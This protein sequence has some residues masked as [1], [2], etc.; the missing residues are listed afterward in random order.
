MTIIYRF[1]SEL[2]CAYVDPIAEKRENPSS[3]CDSSN[4]YNDRLADFNPEP[5]VGEN[6]T[7][8]KG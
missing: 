3:N 1:A 4:A 7:T 5:Q 6:Q 8:T 2:P